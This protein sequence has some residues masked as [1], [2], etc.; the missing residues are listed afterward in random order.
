MDP[1]VVK[2]LG[3]AA[4]TYGTHAF[5]AIAQIVL[6]IYLI[7]NGM[8][9]LSSKKELGRIV[10]RLGFVAKSDNKASSW[11]NWLMIIAGAALLLPL[12]GV[13]FWVAVLACPL[14]M[15]CTLNL[16]TSNQAHGKRQPGDL[17]RKVLVLCAAIIFCF[18]L[19]EGRDLIR[20]GWDVNYKAI[21]WRHKEV[22][23]WQQEN[24]PN[25]PKVGEVA[26]D[27]HLSDLTGSN[28]VR[29]SDFKGKKPVVLFFGSFT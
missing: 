20:V 3:L 25:V 23:V 19:W 7:I 4:V 17:P 29:L 11:V 26:P 21:Y 9:L 13:T 2:Y 5:L 28:P 22:T 18:T 24:N 16:V 27:F 15:Y 8:L 6:S 1:M 12:F 10:T 14:A